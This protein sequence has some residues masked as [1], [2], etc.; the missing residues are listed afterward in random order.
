MGSAHPLIQML[1]AMMGLALMGS[2]IVAID[3]STSAP[4]T[5]IAIMGSSL[6]A[7]AREAPTLSGWGKIF[8]VLLLAARGVAYLVWRRPIV[9]AKAII[10]TSP[11]RSDQAP[12]A[13]VDLRLF[14]VSLVVVEGLA[15][16]GLVLWSEG[17]RV[18]TMDKVGTV[19]AAAIIAFV[20][21][22]LIL[23]NRRGPR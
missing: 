23:A 3:V 20:A 11:L 4:T 5:T 17:H 18:S 15:G 21:H 14:L 6:P 1:G 8:I 2:G 7:P 16:I 22:L 10:E 19:G 9:E 12:M 13:M